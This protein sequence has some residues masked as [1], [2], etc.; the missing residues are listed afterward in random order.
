LNQPKITLEPNGD[1]APQS[2][3]DATARLPGEI[4]H[5]PT[6]VIAHPNTTEQY[7]RKGCDVF[8]A[9]E[10][11]PWAAHEVI[12]TCAKRRG[13]SSHIESAVAASDFSSNAPNVRDIDG[14]GGEPPLVVVVAVANC[15]DEA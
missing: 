4:A 1:R 6:L 12:D 15:I 13:A 9:M 14:P 10:H 11:E 2:H 7:L 3:I 5:V 8:I